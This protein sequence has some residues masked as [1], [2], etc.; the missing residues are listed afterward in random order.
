MD[1][2]ALAMCREHEIPVVVFD[3]ARKGN[4][5]RVIEGEHLGTRVTA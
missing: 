5:R 2:T 1:A 4:I 3:F